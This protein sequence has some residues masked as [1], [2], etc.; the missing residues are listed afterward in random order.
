MPLVGHGGT[1]RVRLKAGLLTSEAGSSGGVG[2]EDGEPSFGTATGCWQLGQR[3]EN[4]MRL[5]QIS[6]VWPH[7]GHEKFMAGSGS[8]GDLIKAL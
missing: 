2:A 5:R 3:T 4:P 8:Y 1:I 7:C 6:S